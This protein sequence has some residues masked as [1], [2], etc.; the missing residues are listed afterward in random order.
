MGTETA[1]VNTHTLDENHA[2]LTTDSFDASFGE[3]VA[4]INSSSELGG[5][6]FDDPFFG[7]FDGLDMNGGIGDDLVRELGE[8]WGATP[9]KQNAEE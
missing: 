8:E 7:S 6:R 2:F 3:L 9:A 4:A 5:L 1:R